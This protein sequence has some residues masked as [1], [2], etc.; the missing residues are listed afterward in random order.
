M[1]IWYE[2]D[3]FD[4]N[5][6]WGRSLENLDASLAKVHELVYGR[7]ATPNDRRREV[8]AA[9]GHL[10]H[11]WSELSV[12]LIALNNEMGCAPGCTPPDPRARFR[13]TEDLV[14]RALQWFKPFDFDYYT[15]EED[16][17]ACGVPIEEVRIRP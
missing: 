4:I 11:A 13:Q 3:T 15:F 16:M 6:V 12:L 9:V 2:N 10:L 8:P 17:V 1:A 14:H 7:E 5:D